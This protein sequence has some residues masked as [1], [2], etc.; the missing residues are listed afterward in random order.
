M[1]RSPYQTPGDPAPRYLRVPPHDKKRRMRLVLAVAAVAGGY[2]A[3]SFLG[4]E[5]G[6]LRIHALSRE[7]EALRARKASLAIRA[8]DAERARKA[9][10]KDPLL[11]ERVAR[12]R[13]RL[14][15]K[16]E[17]VYYYREDT[18]VGGAADGAVGGAGA[19]TP[20]PPTDR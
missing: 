10:K 6:L 14:V 16:D 1:M 15:K 9:A 7:N 8:E 20:D 11:E 19:V 18:A 4:S 13:F 5:S 2:L 3:W 17:M 12:E